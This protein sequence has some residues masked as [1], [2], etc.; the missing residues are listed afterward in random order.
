MK[1]WNWFSALLVISFLTTAAWADVYV[2]NK[3]FEGQVTGSGV[4]TLVDAKAMLEALGVDDFDLQGGQ[5]T[6]NDQ[7][8]SLEGGLVSLKALSDAVGAKVLINSQLGTIDV[9]KEPGNR[10]AAA[11]DQAQGSSSSGA[12]KGYTPTPQGG[13]WLTDW[14]K[15]TAEAKRSNKPILINFTGSDWCGWCIRL[16]KE[17]FVTD[18]FKS[19]A[20]QNVILMEADFPRQ[21]ALP[22]NVATQNQQLSQRY[23]ITGYPSILFVGA[24]GNPLGP[25]Y[26]Y[27]EGGPEAWIK[28]AEQTM[29]R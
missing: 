8:L 6:V 17:V 18:T 10:V 19:W 3:L 29:K 20:A 24:D 11:P 25:R 26:G 14:E 28:G 15:A 5:L 9:Y 16:K 1:S 27:Q 13:V 21:K 23:Q 22:P 7:T 2:K 4:S 12:I